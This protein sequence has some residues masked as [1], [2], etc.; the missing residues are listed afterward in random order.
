MPAEDDRALAGVT[1]AA[2]PA[3]ENLIAD[4]VRAA[5]IV[6]AGALAS[7]FDK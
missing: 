7:L 1:I 4:P 5:V 2:E 3:T 6:A